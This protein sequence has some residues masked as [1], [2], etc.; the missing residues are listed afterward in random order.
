[1]TIKPVLKTIRIGS[2]DVIVWGVITERFDVDV[3]GL[4]PTVWVESPAGV[5]TSPAAPDFTEHPSPPV[6]RV[7]VKHTATLPGVGWWRYYARVTD[8]PESEVLLL[9]GFEVIP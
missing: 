5:P 7:G 9:G 1:M 2:V 8:S 3:S 6:I 4:S